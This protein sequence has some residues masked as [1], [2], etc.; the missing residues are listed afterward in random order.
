MQATVLVGHYTTFKRYSSIFF[1][2]YKSVFIKLNATALRLNTQQKVQLNPLS[3]D[4]TKWSNTFKKIR[5]QIA[6]E[7]FECV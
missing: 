2:I 1:C 7:L 5:G 6:D 4:P 3:A